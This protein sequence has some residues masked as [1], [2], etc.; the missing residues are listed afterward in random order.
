MS[1]YRW[2][3]LNSGSASP[4]LK[5]S[6]LQ[7]KDAV[8]HRTAGRPPRSKTPH[9]RRF[10][11]RRSPTQI[12]SSQ[13]GGDGGPRRSAASRRRPARAPHATSPIPTQTT[14]AR[15]PRRRA[16]GPCPPGRDHSHHPTPSRTRRTS[17]RPRHP[18]SPPSFGPRPA[19]GRR[20]DPRR[21][22]SPNVLR[23]YPRADGADLT[24]LPPS[25]PTYSPVRNVH[26]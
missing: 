11:G 9:S 23:Q 10:G 21:R 18:H 15:R 25:K 2:K 3:R 26:R 12:R 20:R 13:S 24:M 4:R 5:W 8:T 19:A 16:S 14:D 1:A 6:P 7:A 22:T 17:G